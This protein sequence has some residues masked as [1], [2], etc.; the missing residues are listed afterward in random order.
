MDELDDALVIM[1]GC[2]YE[3]TIPY[4]GISED[5]VVWHRQLPHRVVGWNEAAHTITSLKPLNVR[6]RITTP[7]GPE[8]TAT[9]VPLPRVMVHRLPGVMREGF[10]LRSLTYANCLAAGAEGDVMCE[11]GFTDRSH[12]SINLWELL[13]PLMADF[14]D[15]QPPGTLPTYTAQARDNTTAYL[16][17]ASETGPLRYLTL[18]PRA[19]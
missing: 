5:A 10:L 3:S 14:V 2:W 7:L 6:Q 12:A 19:R 4:G 16:G 9:L 11:L 8:Y 17:F 1:D 15:S 13:P 18:Q